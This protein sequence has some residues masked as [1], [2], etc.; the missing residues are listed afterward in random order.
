MKNR[1][2][3][4]YLEQQTAP[5]IVESDRTDWVEFGEGEYRNQY[6]QFLIELYNSSATHS[7]IVNATSEMIA[8]KEVVIE[9][10]GDLQSNVEL[11]QFFANING[12]GSSVEELLSKTAFDLKLHGSYAWNIIWN[13]DRTKIVQVHHIPVEKL[14]SGKPNAMGIVDE[15]YL[16]NDWT[17]IRKTTE[18]V[19]MLFISMGCIVQEWTYIILLIMWHLL[20]GYLP[21]ILP[22]I[23]IWQISK[24]VLA[25]VF[26]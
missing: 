20:I 22:P 7:A 14:R 9:E 16:S 13:V 15:Y 12:K 4:V 23:F 2:S 21:I 19:L 25:L 8:G 17:Q 18:Q 11:K 10:D 1:L 3:Q 26:G 6:P 24:M 5:K